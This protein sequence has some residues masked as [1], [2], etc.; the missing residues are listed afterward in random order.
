MCLIGVLT[1]VI[2]FTVIQD[3]IPNYVPSYGYDEDDYSKIPE[4]TILWFTGS[5]LYAAI[6]YVHEFLSK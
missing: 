2:P 1:V 5:S 4:T 3:I 6:G